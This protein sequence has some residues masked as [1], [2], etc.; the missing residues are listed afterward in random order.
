MTCLAFVG[1]LYDVNDGNDTVDER[2]TG[3]DGDGVVTMAAYGLLY[4]MI[5]RGCNDVKDLAHLT[6]NN[7]A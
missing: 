4:V 3:R 7:A 1:E 6:M 5:V 2:N